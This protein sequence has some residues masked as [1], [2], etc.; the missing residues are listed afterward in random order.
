MILGNHD[1][2]KICKY[3]NFAWV[4]DIYQGKMVSVCNQKV[5]LYHTRCDVW[6]KS[7]FGVWHIY[8]HS[9]GT[10]NEKIDSLSLDCGVDSWNYTPVNHDEIKNIMKTRK[11]NPIDHHGKNN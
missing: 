9:H 10:L 5:F 4:S 11:F 3:A 1:N 2:L 7:H 8:G 6:D